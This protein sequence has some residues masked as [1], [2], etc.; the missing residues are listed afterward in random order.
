MRGHV[1]A[2]PSGSSLVCLLA[3][4]ISEYD[5]GAAAI[6]EPISLGC[7]RGV[8]LLHRLAALLVHRPDTG[9]GY[10]ERPGK[11]PGVS[12]YLRDSGH[13]MAG[14]GASLATI[15]DGLSAAGRAGDAPGRF[16]PYCR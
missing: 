15:R 9:P 1:P 5:G 16:G 10:P 14:L 7:F 4:S 12:D 6:Q 2:A 3:L 8:D 11:K 13:G